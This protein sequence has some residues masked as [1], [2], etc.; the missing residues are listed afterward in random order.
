MIRRCSADARWI[1]SASASAASSAA[2]T[3]VTSLAAAFTGAVFATFFAFR[4]VI[5]FFTGLVVL[6]D[7]A[8]WA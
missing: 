6:S 1:A 2:S 4:N 3:W 7:L 5:A 8:A